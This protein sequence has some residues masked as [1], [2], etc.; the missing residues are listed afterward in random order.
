MLGA[1]DASSPQEVLNGVGKLSQIW[2]QLLLSVKGKLVPDAL[3]EGRRCFLRID[4]KYRV[5]SKL[6]DDQSQGVL[7]IDHPGRGWKDLG[8][9]WNPI[10]FD[11][12]AVG[13]SVPRF[14]YVESLGPLPE[15]GN[16]EA[17][18][19]G[20]RRRQPGVRTRLTRAMSSRQRA[21]RVRC[22]HSSR[23]K[24][25]VPHDRAF[26]GPSS[27]GPYSRGTRRN[28]KRGSVRHPESEPSERL[29]ALAA[30]YHAGTAGNATAARIRR[31]MGVLIVDGV[32]DIGFAPDNTTIG[33]IFRLSAKTSR[34]SVRRSS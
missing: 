7:L 8:S 27:M 9:T 24:S 22:A 31:G 10:S 21:L 16:S 29:G 1:L 32:P 11:G 17:R 25:I 4:P 12:H 34:T 6:T 5:E 14:P 2:S 19:W 13:S 23:G 15:I 3:L 26:W 18:A 33:G 20:T 28:A 30:V